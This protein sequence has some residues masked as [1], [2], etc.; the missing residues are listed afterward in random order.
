MLTNINESVEVGEN[1]DHLSE[2]EIQEMLQALADMDEEL[3]YI[4]GAN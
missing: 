2:E 1:F 3:S 4:Y